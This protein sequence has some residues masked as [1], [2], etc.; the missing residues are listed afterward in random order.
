MIP[1]GLAAMAALVLVDM[2]FLVLVS[3]GWGLGLVALWSVLGVGYGAWRLR[4]LDSNLIFYLENRWNQGEPI[5]AE[6]WEEGLMVLGAWALMTPGF[7]SDVLG[8]L[9]LFRSTRKPVFEGLAHFFSRLAG[10]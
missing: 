5:V 7:L 3:T 1:I 9:V 10:K 8:L 2:I 6:L 4:R